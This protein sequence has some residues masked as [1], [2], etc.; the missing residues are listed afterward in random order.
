MIITWQVVVLLGL[1]FTF[2]FA[3]LW[4]YRPVENKEKA[5]AI[6]NALIN[7]DLNNNQ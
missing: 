1:I 2:V 7:F 4:L 3:V 5:K 6:V